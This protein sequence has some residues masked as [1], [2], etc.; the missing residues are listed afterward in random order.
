ME[1]NIFYVY[2]W[3]REDYNTPFYIGK[4]KGNRYKRLDNRKQYFMNIYNSVPTHVEI[5][6]DK[7]TEEKALKLEKDI[8]HNLVFNENYSIDVPDYKCEKNVGKHL[9][10]LTWGG[11]GT[12]GFTFKQSKESVELR[13]SKN[14][15]KKRSQDQ[16]NNLKEGA[17]KRFLDPNERLKMSKIRKGCTTSDKTKEILR[18]QKLGKKLSEE[19]KN[20]IMQTKNS[21]TKEEKRIINEVIKQKTRESKGLKLYCKE[22]DKT[23]LSITEAN[24][25]FKENY[26]EV[27]NKTQ[28]RS[29]LNGKTKKDWYKEIYIDGKLT[30]LHWEK[31]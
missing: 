12:C 9:T 31:L 5:I 3:I 24:E 28:I 13:A 16:I 23:F 11:E 17:R 21:K 10:N 7:L 25:Y 30:K 29:L 4:G 19:H 6:K 20:K 18:Q 8:I 22:L 15:G 14:R 2:Q 26:N 27:I 1:N